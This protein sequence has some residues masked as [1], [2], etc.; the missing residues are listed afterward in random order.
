[1]SIWSLILIIIAGL[2]LGPWVFDLVG[3]IFNYISK[4]FY[5]LGDGL[6]FFNISTVLNLVGGDSI[7]F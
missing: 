1:M 5:L 7:E 2:L 6:D 4:L 3:L